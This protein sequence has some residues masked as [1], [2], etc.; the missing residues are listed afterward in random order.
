MEELS[1]FPPDNFIALSHFSLFGT[2]AGARP[3]LGKFA[4]Y[5]RPLLVN[6]TEAILI[7]KHT[8]VVGSLLENEE[9]STH[10]ERSHYPL[11]HQF[12]RDLTNGKPHFVGGDQLHPLQIRNGNLDRKGATERVAARA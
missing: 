7:Q 6:R 3:Q 10:T 11:V 2:K 12:F 9:S 1:G 5:L 4:T 8:I